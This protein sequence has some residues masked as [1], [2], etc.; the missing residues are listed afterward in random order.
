MRLLA[1]ICLC[2]SLACAQGSGTITVSGDIPSP[3]VLKADDLSKMPRENP[4]P[5]SGRHESGIR[6]RPAP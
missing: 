4:H 2:A 3:L 6:R 5:R 1:S